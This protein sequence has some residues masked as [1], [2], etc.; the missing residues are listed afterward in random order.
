M[1]STVT[2]EYEHRLAILKPI[3]KKLL[4]VTDDTDALVRFLPMKKSLINFQYAVKEYQ[5][6]LEDV[7][8]SDDDLANLYLTHK[9]KYGAPRPTLN[10]DEAETMLEVYSRRVCF[11][12]EEL[13]YGMWEN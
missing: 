12:I 11:A 1:L 3:I 4:T 10:H 13:D 6:A 7:L 9:Q 2:N 8:Q 5:S